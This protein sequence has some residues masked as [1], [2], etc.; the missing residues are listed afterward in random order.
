MSSGNPGRRDITLARDAVDLIDQ[1]EEEARLRGS[2][3]TDRHHWTLVACRR[4]FIARTVAHVA[5]LRAAE[6]AARAALDAGQAGP[7]LAR[8]EVVDLARDLA[9]S[10]DET[11]VRAWHVVVALLRYLGLATR[12][13]DETAASSRSGG[14]VSPA[15]A[16]PAGVLTADPGPALAP[17]DAPRPARTGPARPARARAAKVETPTL[18]ACGQDWTA[19]A[20][21]GELGPVV[22]R[23]G[24]LGQLVTALCRTSKPNALLVGEPGTGKS[25][26]VEGLARRIA[27]GEVPAVLQGRRLVALDMSELVR[28]SRY[29]GAMEA[30]LAT[31]I[32]EARAV[33]AILFIDEA[34]TMVNAGGREG[35]GD[36]ASFL[37]PVLARGDLSV[38]AATTEDEYRRFILPNGALERRFN[39]VRVLEPDRAAVREMLGAHRDAIAA[40]HGVAVSDAAIERMLIV[41]AGRASHRREPD[42][43]RDL[44]EQAVARALA[45]G[46]QTVGVADVDAAA[47]AITGVPEA[48]DEVLGVVERELV[49]R[50]LLRPEDAAGLVARLGATLAGLV[51]HPERPRAVVLV[52]G[53]AAGSAGAGIAE[54]LAT[55]VFGA[56]ERVV[57]IDVGGLTEPSSVSAL[58]GTTAGYVGFGATLPIHA[59]AER[60]YSVLRLR[61]VGSA[62]P[63][64]RDLIVRGIRDGVLTD[65]TSRRIPLSQSIVVLEA[66]LAAQRGRPLGFAAGA[67]AG[68]SR[69]STVESG[70]AS[71][72]IARAIA[73]VGDELA[74][75]CD[76]VAVPPRGAGEGAGWAAQTLAGLAAG[77]RLAGVELSWTADVARY[78]ADRLAGVDAV[79][80]REREVE[81]LIGPVARACIGA[82]AR[83][84]GVAIRIGE[85]GLEAEVVP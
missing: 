35:T 27:A 83:P 81:T 6:S 28:D 43:T 24:E 9:R 40:D 54:I 69:T 47:A 75:E 17:L 18:D 2:I 3:T 63:T 58:L 85:K 12:T 39:L 7:E 72:D 19:A 55:H 60:P 52:V 15:I 1:V 37:K 30:R 14:P 46:G 61:G 78:L 84:V 74:A 33:R 65:A 21:R 76:L 71:P 64:V 34:H 42:R 67:P 59:L 48:S 26:I 56:P 70:R 57:S 41:T 16:E 11:R 31:L 44:L 66:P 5:D 13:P 4:P 77:Y 51:V 50:S 38:I 29:F 80:R 8:A 20:A 36:V 73:L 32:T 10:R 68:P 53:P 49:R 82:A 62:H 23:D 25:A 22:G 45:T 79:H